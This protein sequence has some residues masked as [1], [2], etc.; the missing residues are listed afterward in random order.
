MLPYLLLTG[1]IALIAM[2]ATE[3]RLFPLLWGL[4]FI[5][6]LIFVGLR[7][8]VGMDWNNYLIMIERANTDDLIDAFEV[9][10]PG[11]VLILR[12]A[13]QTG[14]GVYGAYFLGTAI[15]LLGLFRFAKTT[16][17]PWLALLAAMPIL[18][19]VVA[20]SAARQAVAIG[21]LLW[22]A[23]NWN[24]SSLFSRIAYIL[25]ATLFHAS[26]IFFLIL[27]A[28]DLKISVILK[29]FATAVISILV[30][31][32]IQSMGRVDYYDTLYV[33]GQTEATQSEGAIYHVMLNGIPAII[34]IALSKASGGL[35]MPHAFH[36][37]MSYLATAMIPLALVTSAAAGRMSLYLF[38]VS[39]WFFSAVPQ[40]IKNK[41]SR[42]AIRFLIALLL[43]SLQVAW[44]M[45]ANTAFTF[46]N[47]QNALFTPNSA[48]KLCCR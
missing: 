12:I 35:L 41:S 38:T 37:N 34:A 16:P 42:S 6:I 17:E 27:A 31:Y 39:M 18:V 1:F 8:H 2:L 28:I 30:L 19:S 40:M 4:V 13:G 47:Y 11:Y 46:L 36:R 9:A 21:V 15:F 33:T 20:M 10:E 22:L 26:A 3:R 32:I 5:V 45:M 43:I 48:L 23:A 14:T 25:L 7:H 44:L 29:F 24:Q